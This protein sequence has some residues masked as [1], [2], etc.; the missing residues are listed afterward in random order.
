SD[1]GRKR[2]RFFC[3]RT[4][5]ALL[6]L[7]LPFSRPLHHLELKRLYG[8]PSRIPPGTLEGYSRILLRPQ[9]A[10]NLLNVVRCWE[11][12]LLAVGAAIERVRVPTLLIWG[13]KDDA[14]DI[15]SSDVLMEKLPACERAII[16]DAGHL[17]FEETP[18]EFNRLVLGF[19]EKA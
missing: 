2:I 13:T 14:V 9:R 10:Q 1:F 3:G 17:T 7:G 8:D 6:R 12:D 15:R 16:P 19:L 4:G 11:R 18:D 5:G